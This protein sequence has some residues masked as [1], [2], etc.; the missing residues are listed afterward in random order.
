[1]ALAQGTASFPWIAAG[2]SA[3]FAGLRL[4]CLPY[5][6][7][8]ASLFHAWVEPLAPSIDVRPVQLPGRE[9]RLPE[10]PFDALDPL[11]VALADAIEPQLDAP[12][13]LFGYSMGALIVFEL[14]RTLVR[15]G[16]RAPVK[17]LA[18]AHRAPHLEDPG[19]DIHAL[20]EARFI[21]AIRRLHGTP[22]EVLDHPELRSLLLPLLRADFTLC[23]TYRYRAGE[24]LDC[25][26]VA[27][28]GTQDSDISRR[29]LEAWREHT[30]ARFTLRML[31]GGH[32]FLHTVRSALL[33]A[34]SEELAPAQAAH[35]KVR[36]W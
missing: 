35:A 7:G 27:F 32:F 34:I 31:P 26:I 11:V 19:P 36:P 29:E 8:G 2:R 1:M 16:A 6:G 13:A 14:A 24:P 18:A 4:F 23:E 30:R 33:A 28:G 25:P 21:Q 5:A 3:P 15:T 22:D 10:R 20:P 9:N 12:Y 17:L